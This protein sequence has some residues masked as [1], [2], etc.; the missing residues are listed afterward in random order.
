MLPWLRNAACL[1]SLVSRVALA[2][3]L[4]S[5][6]KNSTSGANIPQVAPGAKVVSYDNYP[7]ALAA[8]ADGDVD[9]VT[10]DWMIL[11]GVRLNSSDPDAYRLTGSRFSVEPYGIALR[12]DDSNWRDALNAALM[13]LWESGT[14]Q[15]IYEN[16]FGENARYRT[17]ID[18]AVPVVPR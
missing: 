14:W 5:A 10:S 16:W 9:A 1:T 3:R 12:E 4:F 6:L 7:D 17:V 15:E 2:F 13:D 8:L 18:F 11:L